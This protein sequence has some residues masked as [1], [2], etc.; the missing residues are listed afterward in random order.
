MR[1]LII[2][3]MLIASA[4]VAIA[5]PSLTNK[6]I[7][8]IKSIIDDRIEFTCLSDKDAL[9]A[10]KKYLEDKQTYA[11]TNSFSE[12][13]KIIVDNLLATEIISHM[14]QIDPKDPEI[15]TF[16][17]PKVEKAAQWIENHKK[18]S[19]VSAY[20]YCTTAEII[21][22]GLSYMT[23]GEIMSYGLKIKDFFVK[24]TEIDSS[25]AFAYS[26]L[27]QWYYHAPGIAGGSTKK[28]YSNFELAYQNA[29]TKGEKFM[30]NMYLS[31]SYYDQKKYEKAAEY[32][33][34]AERIL[35]ESRLIKYI[36]K[37]ND[38]GYGYYYYM[39]NREKVEKKV[40]AME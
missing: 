24:A 7:E 11:D 9:S 1:K 4:A 29:S 21:S 33:A 23:M 6:E 35:P 27:A 26:G 22:C 20:L 38:A 18:D 39:I 32:L 5:V 10:S 34:T 40:G 36:K 19:G 14:Y 13:A 3:I 30:T 8:T 17:T 12:Q 15:K 28:A 37:L 16:I 25:V 31:Q 2:C